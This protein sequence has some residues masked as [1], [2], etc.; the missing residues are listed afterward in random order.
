MTSVSRR[1]F[2]LGAVEPLFVVFERSILVEYT[3]GANFKE[4]KIRVDGD[5][6]LFMLRPELLVQKAKLPSSAR[7]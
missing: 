4:E 1:N 2:F 6:P 5:K 7:L 3:T